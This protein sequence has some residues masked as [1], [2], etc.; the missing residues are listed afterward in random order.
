M[1]VYLNEKEIIIFSGATLG[2]IV[3]AYSEHSYKMLKSG[4][5][6]IFDRFGFLTEP[7]GPIVEGQHFFLKIISKHK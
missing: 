7:D 5:L 1:K 3:L 6:G 4:N 2:D